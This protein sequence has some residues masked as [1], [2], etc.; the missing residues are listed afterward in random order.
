MQFFYRIQG[1]ASLDSKVLLSP[2]SEYNQKAHR[3]TC[4]IE[5]LTAEGI[6]LLYTD[7]HLSKSDNQIFYSKW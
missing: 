1:Q 2:E 4:F 7:P 6:S 3:N 5:P